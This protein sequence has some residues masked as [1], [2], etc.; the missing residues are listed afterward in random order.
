MTMLMWLGRAGLDGGGFLLDIA[1]VF[2]SYVDGWREGIRLTRPETGNHQRKWEGESG[3]TGE[4]NEIS[5]V[6]ACEGI[7][8]LSLS[9][10]NRIL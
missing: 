8:I 3:N 1:I 4:W 10:S 6:K 5:W 2:A 7:F 9:I